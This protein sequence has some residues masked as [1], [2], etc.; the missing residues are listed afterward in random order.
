MQKNILGLF[1][2]M[3]CIGSINAMDDKVSDDKGGGRLEDHDPLYKGLPDRVKNLEQDVKS[4]QQLSPSASSSA[5]SSIGLRQGQPELAQ[6]NTRVATLE[7]N[8]EEQKVTL[9]QLSN[10]FEQFACALGNK[11]DLANEFKPTYLT[12]QETRNAVL[13]Y[14]ATGLV[15]EST[16]ALA[17][18]AGK[19]LMAT[20]GALTAKV[21]LLPSLLSKVGSLAAPIVAKISGAQ[22]AGY[23]ASGA[24]GVA[25][26]YAVPAF[27]GWIVFKT[28]LHGRA[29]TDG[30]FKRWS[31]ERI[32]ITVTAQTD[33][34]KGKDDTKTLSSTSTVT[35]SV[36]KPTKEQELAAAQSNNWSI[37]YSRFLYAK[38]LL[39]ETLYD[40]YG[41]PAQAVLQR[42][43]GF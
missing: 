22:V 24:A 23:T 17:L 1:L 29:K 26:S 14:G 15:F 35:S 20:G 39:G 41:K 27:L 37:A 21:P 11:R 12:P 5:S 9:K 34:D 30:T 38:H 31:D 8:S 25:L 13:T 6:T 10:N 19:S 42:V 28:Y 40:M 16:R 4:L 7:K 2:L 33:K 32:R 36:A 3:T 18:G 43:V